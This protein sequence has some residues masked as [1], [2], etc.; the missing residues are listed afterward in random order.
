MTRG[1]G[2]NRARYR[3]GWSD[4]AT[5]GGDWIQLIGAAYDRTI[6]AFGIE[7]TEQ[8]DDEF[9]E[10]FNS[11]P[12]QSHFNL[13]FRNCADFERQA[14]DFYYPHA[15]HR[16]FIADAGIMTPKQAARSLLG[17]SKRHKDL[18]FS[19]F[20]IPQVPGT[21]HRSTPIR[22][23]LESF[24][25]SKRYALPLVSVAFLHP[26]FGRILAFAWLEGERFDPPPNRGGDIFARKP[27][28][29]RRRT[30]I[31]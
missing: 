1:G 4:G 15:I 6:Y 27:I 10:K 28:G 18:Q 14:V 25:R 17:Y 31:E 3:A 5:P 8:Q 12:N 24:V 9:I 23:V 22:G 2:G 13:L 30:G 19:S 16:S 29:D 26:L 20:V 7:T 21:T 11:R